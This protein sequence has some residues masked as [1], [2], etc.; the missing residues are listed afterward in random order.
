MMTRPIS[1]AWLIA[2]WLL[3]TLGNPARAAG[4]LNLA[5]P[6]AAHFPEIR[7]YCYPS[8]GGDHVVANL[9]PSQF[10][11]REDGR[12]ATVLNV[13]G[14]GADALAVCLVLDRSGSMELPT[15]SGM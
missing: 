5:Q 12:D 3:L 13:Q 15:V 9:A 7:L 1:G 2:A 6:D 14:G 4:S 11:V 10:H 8:S